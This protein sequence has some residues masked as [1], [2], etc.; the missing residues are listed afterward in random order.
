MRMKVVLIR[1]WLIVLLAF[2]VLLALS[3]CCGKGRSCST[4]T[5]LSKNTTNSEVANVPGVTNIPA[6][7]VSD[8]RIK[9]IN[10]KSRRSWRHVDRSVRK[11]IE[12][13]VNSGQYEIVTV[14]THSHNG[15]VKSAEIYYRVKSK[16]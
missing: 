12:Q 9:T 2:F 13:F 14:T 8:L 5:N 1:L 3:G 11:Q 15:Y 10:P 6:D 7:Q 4:T 16:K